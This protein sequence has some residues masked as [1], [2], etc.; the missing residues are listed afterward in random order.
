MSHEV[1][2]MIEE[3]WKECLRTN[4]IGPQRIVKTLCYREYNMWAECKRRKFKRRNTLHNHE[5][6]VMYSPSEK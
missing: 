5:S 3:K 1:C 4:F 6:S 2:K